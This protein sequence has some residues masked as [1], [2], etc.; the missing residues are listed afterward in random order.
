MSVM[1]RLAGVRASRSW[2]AVAAVA[3]VF[4]AV[5]VV[6]LRGDADSVSAPAARTFDAGVT[7]PT[8]SAPEPAPQ[9]TGSVSAHPVPTPLAA[10][11]KAEPGPHHRADPCTAV[12]EAVIPDGFETLTTAGITVAWQP[13]P[14]NPGPRD[15]PI[16]PIVVAY[17]AAG[18]LEEAAAFTGTVKRPTLTVIVYSSRDDLLARTKAPTW[19][20]GVYDGGA[21]HVPSS[22]LEPG[23][24]MAVL[25]HELMHAQLHVA[26]G[27]MPTWFDEGLAM[28]FAGVPTLHEWFAML[29]TPV[30]WDVTPLHAPAIDDTD[31]ERAHLLYAESLAMVVYVVEHSP[32]TGV[33]DTVQWLASTPDPTRRTELWEHLFP[34][35]TTRPVL[36]A[37]AQKLFGL[38]IGAELDGVLAAPI[39]CYGLRSL[40]DLGCRS[41][42]D[43]ATTPR[44]LCL[45]W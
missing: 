20:D 43:K 2:I 16:R 30:A 23:V 31:P 42:S 21:V 37:L 39:C 34:R 14:A 40:P 22:G 10:R 41:A 33:K 44:G 25:R 13:D 45:R 6:W 12:G 24:A 5:V 27:C 8:T 7:P 29:R 38:P 15:V 35:A 18:I 36:D 19:A 28:Y 1:L 9:P 17:T 32:M 26:V 4:A 3:A 11:P